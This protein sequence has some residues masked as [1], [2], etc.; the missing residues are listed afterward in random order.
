[1][2]SY[3]EITIETEPFK[4]EVLSGLLWELQPLGIV[5]L[6]HS[7]VLSFD[8]EERLEET[9]KN[10]LQHLVESAVI[11][12]F[13]Y[14]LKTIEEINWNEEW[15]KNLKVIKV[16]D[17]IVIKP[18][19]REYFPAPDEIVITIDPK[20]SFGTGEHQTTKLMLSMCEKFIEPK[21]RVLDVG[22]GTGVL[23]I[24]S[25]LLGADYALGIDNDD[26]CY[27]NALEN[28]DQNHVYG[29][30]EFRLAEIGNIAE[31]DFDFL[32][33]NI[34]KDVLLVIAKDIAVKVKEGGII[35]LS[36]LLFTDEA[37]ILESYTK[38][39]LSFVDKMQLDEWISLA[40]RKETI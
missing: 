33:A 28:I 30:V 11:N 13:E 10:F 32:L 23:A 26:W 7:L 6:D 39:G 25:V 15:E 8:A 27:E 22:T 4:A 31:H 37:D 21:T 1:M 3:Y 19:F 5:E 40:F 14:S 2:R 12:S 24:A 29:N 36:G 9:V 35:I 18:S 16:T 17:R 20:M 34:Q 38:L